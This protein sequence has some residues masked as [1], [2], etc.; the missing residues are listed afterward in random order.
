VY[1]TGSG[2]LISPESD[3]FKRGRGEYLPKELSLVAVWKEP[4]VLGEEPNGKPVSVVTRKSSASEREIFVSSYSPGAPGKGIGRISG[5]GR[6]CIG[7]HKSNGGGRGESCSSTFDP[8]L[9]RN[10]FSSEA[11]CL[12]EG[13]EDGSRSQ[14]A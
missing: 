10:C 7:S 5:D 8:A 4:S 13:L 11:I 9:M 12:N 1:N 14:H 2:S 3:V 6:V